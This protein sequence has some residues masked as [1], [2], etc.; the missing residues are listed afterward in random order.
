M[1]NPQEIIETFLALPTE[2]K[3]VA[4][5]GGLVLV[6]AAKNVWGFIKPVRW[7]LA[8]ILRL[9]AWPLYPIKN[10]K[11]RNKTQDYSSNVCI[12]GTIDSGEMAA[13]Q[14]RVLTSSKKAFLTSCKSLSKS[15]NIDSVTDF[16]LQI[17]GI[18]VNSYGPNKFTNIIAMHSDQKTRVKEMQDKQDELYRQQKK[19]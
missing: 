7:S 6:S 1:L 11:L 12:S 2:Y 9:T 18:G 5:V 8:S 19:S 14:C 16:E 4:G 15:S 3:I 13:N 17:L 10:F